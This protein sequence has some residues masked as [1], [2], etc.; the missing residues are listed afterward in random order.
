MRIVSSLIKYMMSKGLCYGNGN[1]YMYYGSP[2]DNIDYD[3]C[4][5]F[6]ICKLSKS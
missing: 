5:S 3:V 4:T 1:M 6:R 2:V